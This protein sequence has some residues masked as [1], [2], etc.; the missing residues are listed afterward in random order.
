MKCLKGK[1]MRKPYISKEDHEA[2]IEAILE[3]CRGGAHTISQILA[4][5][6]ITALVERYN[7]RRI[8]NLVRELAHSGQ[9]FT[10][11][12]TLGRVYLTIPNAAPASNARTPPDE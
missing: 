3:F 2:A 1:L 4:H 6:P 10:R 9:L 12:Q 8:Q 7:R 5:P 11:G